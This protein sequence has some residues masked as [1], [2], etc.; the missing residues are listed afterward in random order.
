MK[1]RDDLWSGEEQ[2]QRS[3]QYGSEGKRA[4]S[5]AGKCRWLAQNARDSHPQGVTGLVS[6]QG[7][8]K[9]H[10]PGALL[11]EVKQ[12]AGIDNR[13]GTYPQCKIVAA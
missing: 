7:H 10:L 3:G 4:I 13:I 8:G 2:H 6:V 9:V 1:A 11:F 5:A 12:S